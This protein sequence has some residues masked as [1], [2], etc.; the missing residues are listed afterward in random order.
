MKGKTI[1]C[2]L[3]IYVQFCAFGAGSYEKPILETDG[4]YTD[5]DY[6]YDICYTT[7]FSDGMFDYPVYDKTESWEK[8]VVIR[9]Y[10]GDRR[11]IT[12]PSRIKGIP[13]V[14]IG[15]GAF[16]SR[17]LSE[18]T[19][20]KTLRVI[21]DYAFADNNLMKIEFPKSVISIGDMSFLQN[22]L[23]TVVI[24]DNVGF[25][26]Y[27]YYSTVFP[28]DLDNYYIEQEGRAAG[29]YKFVDGVWQRQKGFFEK[30][31]SNGSGG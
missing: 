25:N 22:P 1:L 2:F 30:L 18:V 13:V 7:S 19:L 11:K 21:A 10:H 17:A 9:S 28:N 4:E 26:G 5:G 20:P 12:I 16:H 3:L 14:G 15:N 29:T 23:N 27:Y 8:Y 31:F 6:S 24:G